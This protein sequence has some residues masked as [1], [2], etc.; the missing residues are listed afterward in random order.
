MRDLIDDMTATDQERDWARRWADF[1]L[2]R[3]GGTAADMLR[4]SLDGDARL[5]SRKALRMAIRRA[6]ANLRGRVVVATEPGIVAPPA[7]LA[8]DV[9]K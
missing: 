9:W 2:R 3:F 7:P 8:P 5:K 1:A 6:D 4:R